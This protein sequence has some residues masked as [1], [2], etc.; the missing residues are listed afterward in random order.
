MMVRR[1]A[2]MLGMFVVLGGC[3]TTSGNDG[4]ARIRGRVVG[5]NG[6][7]LDGVRITT[8]PPTDAVLTFDGVYEITREVKSNAPVTPGAY[9]LVPY[10]LGWWLGNEAPRFKIDYPG[11]DFK[12]RDIELLPIVGPTLENVSA[13]VERQVQDERVGSGVIR[14]GE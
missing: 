14:D 11:G 10:K 6:A 13:P 4:P 7:P 3:A 2:A 1:C 12:V 8:D 5:P 9:T